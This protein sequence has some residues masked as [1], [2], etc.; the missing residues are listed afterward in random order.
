MVG[1]VLAADAGS[2]DVVL[3]VNPNM[4]LDLNLSDPAVAVDVR[5]KKAKALAHDKRPKAIDVLL[6]G[7]DSRS[8]ELRVAIIA[9]LKA[10]KGDAVLLQRAADSK[11]T[12]AERVA[13]LGGIRVIK[14]AK[15]GAALAAL[16]DD[17]EE[18]IREAAAYALVVVGP[19]DAEARLVTALK[20][21]PSAKVRYFV[22]VALGEL[23]TPA[24]KAAVAARIKF[25]T[26]FAAK[27]ALDQAVAKQ[28]RP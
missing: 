2:S 10:L 19:A 11:R 18:T 3:D 6:T 21:E 22:I 28:S 7:L 16:L 5:I 9:S 23:K 20:A 13:A 17:K 4:N 8:E 12:P 26:D 24:A 15:A 27:D 25:E 1:G 14:P